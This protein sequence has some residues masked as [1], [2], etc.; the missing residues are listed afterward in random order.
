[1]HDQDAFEILGRGTGFGEDVKGL[2]SVTFSLSKHYSARGLFDAWSLS[3]CKTLE[4]AHK[5]VTTMFSLEDD[6]LQTC[7]D[8]RDVRVFTTCSKRILSA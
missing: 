1:M 5:D 7:L 3:A 6:L 4:V 2:G 8:V